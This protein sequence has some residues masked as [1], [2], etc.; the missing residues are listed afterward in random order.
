MHHQPPATSLTSRIKLSAALALLCGLILRAVFVYFH[1]RWGGDTLV[2]GNLADNMLRHHVFGFSEET[3]RPTLIRLPGYPIFLAACFVLF[4]HANYLAVVCVQTLIDLL[5]CVL[6]GVLAAR[7]WNPRAGLTT[8]WLA[9]LCPFTAS[10]VGAALTETWSIFCV[11]LA[12]FALERWIKKFNSDPSTSSGPWAVGPE[13]WPIVIGLACAYAVLVRP[14]QGLVAAAII[15]AILWLTFSTPNRSLTQRLLPAATATLVVL[16]PLLLWGVRNWRV[17]HVIQPLAPR[18]AND[19]GETVPFGFQRWFRTWGI[20]FKSTYDIYWSYDGAAMLLKDVPPRAFDNPA[21]RAETATLLDAYNVE[22]SG[23][24]EFDAAFAR[25][26][27][28]RIAAHPFSYYILMPV[29]RELNMWLRPRTEL[30]RLPIDWWNIRAHA[31]KSI[32]EIFYALLDVAYLGLAIVGLIGWRKAHWSGQPVLAASMIA[33]VA[34][35]CAL[36]LTLDNSEPRYTLECFPIIIL[37]AGFA[38]SFGRSVGSQPH[39]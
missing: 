2:Y 24:P 28:A 13:P 6:L 32:F 35:R 7:I 15:P 1:P 21:Q 3:V 11:T 30:L 9:A 36:L 8:L 5:G 29:A 10:Y 31:G 14:D 20:D 16:I 18:Y 12:L 4:G 27:D 17:F 39:E 25:L 33:F 19:P 26:A 34:L 38:L 22:Q 23:T 37:L